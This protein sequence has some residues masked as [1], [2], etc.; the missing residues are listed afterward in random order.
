MGDIE[1]RSVE[2]DETS[3]TDMD[4]QQVQRK[5]GNVKAYCVVVEIG[6]NKIVSENMN[7]ENAL[8]DGLKFFPDNGILKGWLNKK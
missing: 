5:Y 1:Q 7:L 6:Y 2:D 4:V 8:N 3:S